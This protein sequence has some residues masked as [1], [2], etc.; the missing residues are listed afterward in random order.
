MAN[1]AG[2]VENVPRNVCRPV[3]LAPTCR[4]YVA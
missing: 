4:F 2:Y 1:I 3:G